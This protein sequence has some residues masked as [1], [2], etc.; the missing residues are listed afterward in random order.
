M[1]IS[2]DYFLFINTCFF[3]LGNFYHNQIGGGG[4]STRSVVPHHPPWQAVLRDY[5]P[6]LF[7]KHPP[8]RYSIPYLLYIHNERTTP[9]HRITFQASTTS[10]LKNVKKYIS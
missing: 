2:I 9:V 6:I 8:A 3:S 10:P 7:T 1:A 4:K 5:T